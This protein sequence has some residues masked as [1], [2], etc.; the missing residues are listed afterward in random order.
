MLWFRRHEPQAW[1]R[2]RRWYN[3]NSYVAAKLTG[4]YVL[5][6]H[7]ASQSDPLYDVRT[8]DWAP[9]GCPRWPVSWRCPGWSGRTR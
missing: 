7:T 6:H 2:G 1:A 4:E 3:S 9:T 5:D 8:F